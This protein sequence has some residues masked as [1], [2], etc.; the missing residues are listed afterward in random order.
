MAP[1]KRAGRFRA[2]TRIDWQPILEEHYKSLPKIKFNGREQWYWRN[3]V[4]KNMERTKERQRQLEEEEKK[5]KERKALQMKRK[6]QRDKLQSVRDA[7]T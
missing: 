5:K 7:K 4:L 2:E 3:S 6:R 1:P